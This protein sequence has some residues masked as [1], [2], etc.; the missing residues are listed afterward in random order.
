MRIAMQDS[1][2]GRYQVWGAFGVRTP[3]WHTLCQ[4]CSAINKPT[5]QKVRTLIS[6]SG[7]RLA[8]DVT[9]GAASATTIRSSQAPFPTF[10]ELFLICHLL[11]KQ[12]SLLRR[13]PPARLNSLSPWLRQAVAFLLAQRAGLDRLRDAARASRVSLLRNPGRVLPR[14]SGPPGVPPGASGARPA[15]RPGAGPLGA[16]RGPRRRGAGQGRAPRA[17]GAAR[18]LTHSRAGR[19]PFCV[20]APNPGRR[21]LSAALSRPPSWRT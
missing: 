13:I 1:A 2:S 10:P 12:P 7:G 18:G 17:R 5:G 6:S 15:H 9:C 11:R 3:N 8:T 21:W 14:L 4:P 16:R 20:P 19:E